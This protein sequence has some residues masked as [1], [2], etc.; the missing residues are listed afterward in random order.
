MFSF[1]FTF[2]SF[3]LGLIIHIFYSV[4]RLNALTISEH[5]KL[6]KRVKNITEYSSGQI[7]CPM[8]SG[9]TRASTTSEEHLIFWTRTFCRTKNKK[10]LD[11][12]VFSQA[13]KTMKN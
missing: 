3:L 2:S 7:V 12:S 9:G 6:K 11:P 1:H 13:G 10:T 4:A 5:V 8:S